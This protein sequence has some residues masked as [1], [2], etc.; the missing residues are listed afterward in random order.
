MIDG[1]IKFMLLAVAECMGNCDIADVAVD[2]VETGAMAADVAD[3][4]EFDE[5]AEF[6]TIPLGGVFPATATPVDEVEAEASTFEMLAWLAGDRDEGCC[7]IR[8]LL[9]T[10]RILRNKLV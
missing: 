8:R 3:D 7:C 9:E 4:V 5:T 1:M 10:R 6:D 2:D